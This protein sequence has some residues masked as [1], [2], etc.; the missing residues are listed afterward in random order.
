[1]QI[2]ET[3]KNMREL[4]AVEFR[5]LADYAHNLCGIRLDD[6]KKYLVESR[7]LGLLRE[8][9]CV[10]YGDLYLKA[11]SDRSLVLPQ[12]IVEA[13]TTRETMFF[14]DP[15]IFESLEKAIIPE[16]IERKRSAAS[17]CLKSHI[18]I[19]CAGCSTGQEVYS[20]AML[21]REILGSRSDFAIRILGL[22]IS[23]DALAYARQGIYSESEVRRG[24]PIDKLDNHFTK[25]STGWKVRDELREW[26]T[27]Q[28]IN[29]MLPFDDFGRFDIVLCRNTAVY[30]AE[31]DRAK[32]FQ[33]IATILDREGCLLVGSTESIS[34]MCSMYDIKRCHRVTYYQLKK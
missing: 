31:G 9:G 15:A 14:R 26:V 6:S 5:T 10:S 29:L 21:M 22:D 13:L 11:K 23:E 20:I 30:F 1:M 24:L 34:D 7:L 19:L 18:R 3:A 25:C 4:S 2:S 12:K 17:K 16:I 28:R 27:F 8:T 32:L 33:R